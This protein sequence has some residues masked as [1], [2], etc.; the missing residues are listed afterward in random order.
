MCNH[1]SGFVQ[2]GLGFKAVDVMHMRQEIIIGYTLP[3]WSNL[4]QCGVSE[5]SGWWVG[6]WVGE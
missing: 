1:L 2:P 3:N 4:Q 6:G 5:V